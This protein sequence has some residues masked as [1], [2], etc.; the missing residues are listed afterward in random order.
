M[1]K[2]KTTKR[3]AAPKRTP[4]KAKTSKKTAPKR[5]A[6]KAK[7]TVRRT[8]AEA[9]RLRLE[10]DIEEAQFAVGEARLANRMLLEASRES[11]NDDD[12]DDYPSDRPG[13]SD[14]KSGL[15]LAGYG[16]PG[17]AMTLEAARNI[18][19]R[20]ARRNPKARG[21][22]KRLS[23]L[24][25]GK[26]GLQVKIE[27]ERAKDIWERFTERRNWRKREREALKRLLRDGETLLRLWY[28]M[29]DGHG[30]DFRFINPE[31]LTGDSGH[32]QG[33]ETWPGDAELV[34]AFHVKRGWGSERVPATECVW[35]KTGVDS[36]EL[37]GLP[38][39]LSLMDPLT[40]HNSL[41]RSVLTTAKAR[42]AYAII[43]K[44]KGATPDQIATL[45]AAKR[46]GT[47]SVTDSGTSRSLNRLKVRSGTV[48]HT[49]ARTEVD[50][51]SPNIQA[52]DQMN[53]SR[54]IDLLASQGT[55]LAEHYQ[56]M[57]SQ[58]LTEAGVQMAE[59]PTELAVDDW[60]A[61]VAEEIT[62]PALRL[63]LMASEEYAS[64][65]AEAERIAAEAE[66]EGRRFQRRDRLQQVQA[67]RV[68]TQD[69]VMSLRTRQIRDGPD[70]DREDE[71]PSGEEKLNGPYRPGAGDD[72]DD[73]DYDE[74]K[75]KDKARA[76][77][78]RTERGD[79]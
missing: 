47:R 43:M 30:P 36:D 13:S 39:L 59:G 5:K 18:S 20:L 21:I 31:S 62:R 6:G 50:M 17:R 22:L 60:Q 7:S 34:K 52:A 41:L 76:G 29:P 46:T 38:E 9:E 58:G 45:A 11:W 2:R 71:A 75:A 78:A 27:D 61:V 12:D 26:N 73:G 67:D 35:V 40:M 68:Q 25:L 65:P 32:S 23:Q 57:D 74:R 37:R 1:A 4:S 49:G 63:V 66:I 10:L 14:P 33:I 55:G 51:K 28:R 8:R 15:A 16:W 56:R 69:R 3:R 70:P 72:D 48:L 19:R 79:A 44:H 42:N 64:S 53:L 54:E 24:T 77:A